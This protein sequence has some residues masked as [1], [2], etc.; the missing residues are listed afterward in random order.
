MSRV[1]GSPAPWSFVIL[2]PPGG[3]SRRPYGARGV[4]EVEVVFNR[5]VER[6]GADPLR[7]V[8]R[9]GPHRVA[10]H[11][12][13]ILRQETDV[14]EQFRRIGR[15]RVPGQG[16]VREVDTGDDG[17]GLG[18]DSQYGR[19]VDEQVPIMR[20]STPP[21]PRSN[22]AYTRNA[23]TGCVRSSWGSDRTSRRDRRLRS[24][25]RP[26]ASRTRPGSMTPALASRGAN[27]SGLAASTTTHTSA[28]C[29]CNA[30][31]SLRSSDMRGTAPSSTARSS[32]SGRPADVDRSARS[33]CR[34][35]ANR[36]NSTPKPGSSVIPAS[37]ADP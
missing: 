18:G 16:A 21:G 32:G 30:G 34:C 26:M 3:R 1:G 17:Q 10:D 6:D 4:R 9:H 19:E 35:L 7:S 29:R 22:R 13:L 11:P 33:S 27:S 8:G 12:Y 15:R 23:G 37:G 31:A 2:Q 28:A 25:G 14:P 5:S 20:R 36:A 24:G